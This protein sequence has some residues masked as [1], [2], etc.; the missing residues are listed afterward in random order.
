[1]ILTIP[2]EIGDA[3]ARL[4]M[5]TMRSNQMLSG[6]DYFLCVYFLTKESYKLGRTKVIKLWFC[7]KIKGNFP[8]SQS[9]AK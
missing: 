7:I 4:R 1:M 9:T 6:F 2:P 5:S 8:T 3:Y